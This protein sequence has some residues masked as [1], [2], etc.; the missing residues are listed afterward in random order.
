LRLLAIIGHYNQAPKRAWIFNITAENDLDQLT[1]LCRVLPTWIKICY[2][3]KRHVPYMTST[4]YHSVSQCRLYKGKYWR[5]IS[6]FPKSAYRHL[7]QDAK[8]HSFCFFIFF[9][10]SFSLLSV[11]QNMPWY[12]ISMHYISSM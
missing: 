2:N 10:V 6:C 11:Y 5:S 7:W 12:N 1:D 9:N 8:L 4:G 3:L